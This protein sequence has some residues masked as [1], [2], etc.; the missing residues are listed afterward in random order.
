M[1]Y[2]PNSNPERSADIETDVRRPVISPDNRADS[3]IQALTEHFVM[4]Q[5]INLWIPP[6]HPSYNSLAVRLRSFKKWPHGKTRT[7]ESLNEA[8]FLY[9][10][11]I[12]YN[13]DYITLTVYLN[14]HL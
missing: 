1:E 4:K 5:D 6:R 11:K 2:R 13:F 3:P 7:S 8:G 9:G 14:R 10:G 12:I